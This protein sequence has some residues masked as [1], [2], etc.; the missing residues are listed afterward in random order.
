VCFNS[1]FLAGVPI[2]ERGF[3]GGF[4]LESWKRQ[5]YVITIRDIQVRLRLLL[6]VR[7]GLVEEGRT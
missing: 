2:L 6:S 7:E 1:F 4:N 5:L 3:G